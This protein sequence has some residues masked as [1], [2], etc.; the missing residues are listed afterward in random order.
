MSFIISELESEKL[1]SCFDGVQDYDEDGVDCGG[2]CSECVLIQGFFD[3]VFWLAL[4]SWI[5]F[6]LLILSLG[7]NYRR[8][9]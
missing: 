1:D 5:I 8:V 3:W 7:F 2:G 4:S 6:T 9:F